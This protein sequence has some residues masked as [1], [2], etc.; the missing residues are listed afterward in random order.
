MPNSIHNPQSAIQNV[1]VV[2]GSGYVAN[3]ILPLIADQFNLH[4]LDRNPPQWLDERERKLSIAN[5]QLTIDNSPTSTPPHLHTYTLGDVTDPRALQSAAQNKDI[6][7]YMAM[8][9]VGADGINVPS[10]SHDVNVKGVHLAL[11]AAVNAGIKKAVYTSSLSVYDGQLDIR[12]G[13]TDSEEVPARPR[14]VY[15][16]T[17]LLGEEVCAYFHRTHD[18]PVVVLRLFHPVSVEDWHARYAPNEVYAQTSAPDLA[19]AVS[20]AMKLEHDGFEIVHVTGDTSGQAYK[21]EKAKRLL[22]WEPQE[23]F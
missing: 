9:R 2:G 18:L 13:A 21:H 7:L 15:G 11:E 23:R 6:L 8:G 1:L 19:R 14:T 12:S 16:F 17:K 3:L 22:N 4:V 5:C 10:V 20:A